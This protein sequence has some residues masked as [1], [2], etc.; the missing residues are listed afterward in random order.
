MKVELCRKRSDL[1]EVIMITSENINNI[2]NKLSIDFDLRNFLGC[3]VVIDRFGCAT[4]YQPSAFK[5]KFEIL[6]VYP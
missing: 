3:Y 2:Y 5:E 1:Y 6:E 4:I